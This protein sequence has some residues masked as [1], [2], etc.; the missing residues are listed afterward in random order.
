MGEKLGFC[1]GLSVGA[2]VGENVNILDCGDILVVLVNEDTWIDVAPNE[3]RGDAE[4]LEVDG[5]NKLH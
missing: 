1:V 3:F 2:V 5:E 4:G